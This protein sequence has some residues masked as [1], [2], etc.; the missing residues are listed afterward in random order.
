MHVP[1]HLYEFGLKSFQK[2]AGLVGYEIAEH[3]FTVCSIYHVPRFL[4][5]PLRWWMDRTNTG[6]QLTVY[7]RKPG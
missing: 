3:Q 4:H 2:N 7:L 5:P 6:M 1:F